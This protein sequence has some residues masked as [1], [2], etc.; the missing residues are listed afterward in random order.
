[1]ERRNIY[2]ISFTFFSAVLLFIIASPFLFPAL[3]VHL[4]ITTRRNGGLIK[5]CDTIEAAYVL[6][7]LATFIL[8]SG[9]IILI[10]TKSSGFKKIILF[11]TV[12]VIII[13]TSSLAMA[14]LNSYRARSNHLIRIA[15]LRSISIAQE[16]YYDTFGNYADTFEELKE[17]LFY[18]RANGEYTDADGSGLEGGDTDPQTWSVR[19]YIDVPQYKNCIMKSP[20]YWYVCNQDG[21]NEKS[22]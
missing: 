22:I 18:P 11:L 9:I 19:A 6:I 17:Y 13:T 20:G 4:T 15:D 8:I 21:C 2:S 10:K 14:S 5:I 1:M 3:G 16:L 12:L 7:P